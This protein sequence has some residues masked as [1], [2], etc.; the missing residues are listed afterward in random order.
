MQWVPFFQNIFILFGYG[1]AAAL[2]LTLAFWLLITL[3]KK[4]T[5]I[6]EWKLIG[7]GN[8]AVAIVT[9]AVFISLAI[10]VAAAITPGN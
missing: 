5:P 4:I 7:E 8:V 2:M 10:V 3:W 1:I 6:D 9:A